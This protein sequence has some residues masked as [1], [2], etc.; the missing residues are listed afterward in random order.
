MTV[1]VV[2]IGGYDAHLVIGQENNDS[3]KAKHQRQTSR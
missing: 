1:G 3:A 2:T